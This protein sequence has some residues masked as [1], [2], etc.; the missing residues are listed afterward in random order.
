MY[1]TLGEYLEPGE[2]ITAAVYCV[3]K[4]TGFFASNVNMRAGYAAI[5]DRGRFVGCKMGL[6]DITPVVMDMSYLTKVK[7]SGAI[8]G[9]KAVHMVFQ[10]DKKY[11]IKLQISPKILTSKFPNQESNAEAILN[12]LKAKQEMLS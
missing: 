7:V 10:M 11:E 3:Y 5:T 2:T 12:E 9:Q 6:M 4:P 1:E 8:L